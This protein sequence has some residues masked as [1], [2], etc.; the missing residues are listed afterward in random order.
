[1]T[2]PEW[3]ALVGQVNADIHGMSVALATR[4]AVRRDLDDRATAPTEEFFIDADAFG[5][6][7]T[8]PR[9]FVVAGTKVQVWKTHRAGLGSSD[10]MGADLFYE[11]SDTKFVLIQYK[12]PSRRRRVTHD[13]AQLDVLKGACPF[14]CPPSNRFACGSWLALRSTDGTK[15]FPAC[16]GQQIFGKLKSR[17]EQFFVNGLTR[18]RFHEDFGLCRIGARTQPVDVAQ[19][20]DWSVGEDRV[21]I[22]A[23]T[24]PTK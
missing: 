8:T 15:Y 18:E 5:W 9:D 24:S 17:H 12:T 1:M 6:E 14:Q 10:I 7:P 20:R 3:R 13:A 4:D 22:S 16:E 19:Y 21:F 11:V 2:E 23:L